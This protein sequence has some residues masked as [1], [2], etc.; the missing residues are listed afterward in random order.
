MQFFS[1]SF[2]TDFLPKNPLAFSAYC[3]KQSSTLIEDID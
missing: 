3:I 1:T 2:F